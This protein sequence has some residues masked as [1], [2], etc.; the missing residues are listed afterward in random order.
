MEEELKVKTSNGEMSLEDF[1]ALLK[2]MMK[3][4]PVNIIE[5]HIGNPA[6]NEDVLESKVEELRSQFENKQAELSESIADKDKALELLKQ[7]VIDLTGS[8]QELS[9]SQIV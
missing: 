4:E 5:D 9:L 8:M 7:R 3:V 6:D 1:A 2:P